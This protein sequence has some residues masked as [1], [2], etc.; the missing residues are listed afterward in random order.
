M[1][2]GGRVGETFDKTMYKQINKAIVDYFFADKQEGDYAFLSM[3]EFVLE[4]VGKQA[5]FTQDGTLATLIRV[6]G[7][8]WK[9]ALLHD[10]EGLPQF[11]G[12]IALQT[13]A[14]YQMHKGDNY[15]HNAYNVRLLELLGHAPNDKPFIRD[16]Y[17]EYQDT[18]WQRYKKWLDG[19]ELKH[20][21]PEPRKGPWRYVQYPQ[22]QA[23][24][25]L[26][27]LRVLTGYFAKLGFSP[28]D[29]MERS[30]FHSQ[31]SLTKIPA[32]FLTSHADNCINQHPQST[33]ILAEQ[34]L[35]YFLNWDGVVY[36]V[37]GADKD[38]V[39]YKK[40]QRRRVQ[41]ILNREMSTVTL[42]EEG[43]R[44]AKQSIPVN[45]YVIGQLRFTECHLRWLNPSSEFGGG[46]VVFQY[47]SD[48][49]DYEAVNHI[50]IGRRI[51][52]LIDRSL[53]STIRNYIEGNTRQIRKIKRVSLHSL[54]VKEKHAQQDCPIHFLVKERQAITLLQGGLKFER[55][56]WM[57]GAGP[58]IDLH[59]LQYVR[60]NDKLVEDRTVLRNA[61]AG[62]YRLRVLG[63]LPFVFHIEAPQRQKNFTTN[64]NGW[65]L[66]KWSP[67]ADA[68]N[69]QGLW[70][71]IPEI[72]LGAEQHPVR[73]WIQLVQGNKLIKGS[74]RKVIFQALKR[75]RYG[76]Y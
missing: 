25:N 52:F 61:S 38:T 70:F 68:W 64:E 76:R 26:H 53:D 27:D 67:V 35:S 23:L 44:K 65:L 13:Y 66:E 31:F 2:D 16:L 10:D 20:N 72:S 41:L 18:I 51:V 1:W 58:D 29:G 71:D 57:Q 11:F 62:T 54:E 36:R 39:S 8:D 73:Q 37:L 60:L 40:E 12:L 46:M 21:I 69:Q 22:S 75:S 19:K 9:V 63:Y 59:G 4:E 48:F 42:R 6:F 34:V 74:S 32:E 17:Q 14:A 5:G 55:K 56:V 7:H 43:V 50:Q 15:N 45:E 28:G 24:F 49:E 30:E 33:Q 3:D 47:D